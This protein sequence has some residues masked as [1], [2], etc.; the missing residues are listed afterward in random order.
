MSYVAI[1]P[2]RLESERVTKKNIKL[3]EGFPLIEFTL[4]RAVVSR[5]LDR[6]IVSTDSEEVADV[7]ESLNHEKVETFMRDAR[8]A[9]SFTS[10]EDV[11][12][13]VADVLELTPEDVIVTLLPTSPFRSE[14]L[15]DQSIE[16]MERD[17]S[18]SLLTVLHKKSK[19]GKKTEDGFF[20]HVENYPAEMHKV[21]ATLFDNPAVYLTRL[22]ILREEKFIVG[23]KI[24]CVEIDAIQGHDINDSFDW[25]TAEM[26][27]KNGL[28]ER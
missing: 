22:S 14:D 12:I 18:D 4:R 16:K 13:N 1:I 26:I 10:T 2:A 8:L 24:S 15:I 25:L 6:I 3:L 7:V 9:C 21:E 11:L 17:N 28:F 23:G 5:K 20:E 27:L 19:L